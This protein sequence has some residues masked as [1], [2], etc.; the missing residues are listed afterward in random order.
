MRKQAQAHEF[1]H[2]A[3]GKTV[4][5]F[6]GGVVVSDADGKVIEPSELHRRIGEKELEI[7]RTKEPQMLGLLCLEKDQMIRQ[8]NASKDTG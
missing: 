8:A 3:D 2:L 6:P 1:V 4:E 5:T 7:R